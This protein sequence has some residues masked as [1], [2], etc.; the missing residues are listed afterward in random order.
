[1][2]KAGTPSPPTGDFLGD[3]TDELLDYGPGIY[4][5]SFVSGSLK[6]YAYRVSVGESEDT[7]TVCEFKGIRLHFEHSKKINLDKIEAMVLDPL[8]TQVVLHGTRICR[9]K[10]HYVV[11]RPEEN[12]SYALLLL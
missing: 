3:L 6:N 4:I 5:N 11:S 1:M 7:V 12:V 8:R 2:E 10:K 9:T